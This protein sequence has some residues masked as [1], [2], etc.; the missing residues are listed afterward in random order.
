MYVKGPCDSSIDGSTPRETTAFSSQVSN[1]FLSSHV[2]H[3]IN[4]FLIILHLLKPIKK[5]SI[6]I[7]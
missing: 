3:V 2:L 1:I 4:L 5:N 6:S 7:T